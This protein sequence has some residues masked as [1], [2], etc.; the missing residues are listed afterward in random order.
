MNHISESNTVVVDGDAAVFMRALRKHT[1]LSYG[2]LKELVRRKLESD[3]SF[4][5][6]LDFV[7]ERNWVALTGESLSLTDS[8]AVWLDEQGN[9]LDVEEEDTSSNDKP[10]QCITRGAQNFYRYKCS[11]P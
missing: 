2:E 8:G 9:E 5:P 10:K 3:D 1:S 4:D 11:S 6:V 7:K